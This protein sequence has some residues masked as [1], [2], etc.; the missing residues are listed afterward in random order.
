MRKLSARWVLLLSVFLIVFCGLAGFALV[1]ENRLSAFLLDQQVGLMRQS[2]E[3]IRSALDLYLESAQA[4]MEQYAAQPTLVSAVHYH[5]TPVPFADEFLKGVLGRDPR[6]LALYVFNAK[7]EVVAGRGPGGEDLRGTSVADTPLFQ[8]VSRDEP[9]IGGGV[10]R[11]GGVEGWVLGLGRPLLDKGRVIGGVGCLLDWSRFAERFVLPVRI[12]ASGHAFVQDGTCRIVAHPDANLAFQPG[13]TPAVLAGAREVAGGLECDW[14]GVATIY[15]ATPLDALGWTVWVGAVRADLL[16]GLGVLRTALGAAALLLLILLCGGLWLLIR[17]LVLAPVLAIRDYSRAVADG[18][19]DARIGGSYRSEFDEL[20]ENVL[21]MS[22]MLRAR[23]GFSQ[24]V[25]NCLPV[26]VSIVDPEDRLIFTNKE[27]LGAMG[28]PGAPGDYLG[29][30]SSRFVFGKEGQETLLC[31]ALRD[32][33]RNDRELAFTT[34]SGEKRVVEATTAPILGE[35]GELFGS[36]ALWFEI[37]TLREQQA[38]IEAQGSVIARAAE[39]AREVVRRLGEESRSLGE[40]VEVAGRGASEQRVRTEETA[41]AVEQMNA[42][43]LEVSRSAS[44]SAAQSERVREEGER[45]AAVAR[46]TDQAIESVRAAFAGVAENLGRL[47][48]Q[49]HEIAAI[50][51]VIDDI[52]DQTNLLALNAAIEAARAGD[53]G[54]GFAVVAG[55]VRKLAEKTTDATKQVAR[56]TGAIEEAVGQCDAAMNAAVRAVETG[57]SLSR[58]AGEALRAIL[59]EASSAAAQSQAIAAAAE[60]QSAASE[61]I[62]RTSATVRSIA[63]DTA[64]AM[65]RAVAI[66]ER[67]RGL[68]EDLNGIVETMRS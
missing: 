60:Q 37:T 16:S 27:M 11:V 57:G 25:L 28:K 56:S 2:G 53:A 35:D 4:D 33:A 54:R 17:R 29:W 36:I 34:P 6:F 47:G 50:L 32:K 12:G 15:A 68:S 64:E 18:D 42:S 49:A 23:L 10:E 31:L 26:P 30:S 40:Q 3:R 24:G 61:Q 46:E 1:L 63:R 20:K 14:R 59:D 21:R 43:I 51:G 65:E 19:L 48:E 55:E 67:L 5:P 62:A 41:T 9:F 66:G 38:R 45:G 22:A 58:Q 8:A 7:G 52:A 13:L 39:Q 44:M